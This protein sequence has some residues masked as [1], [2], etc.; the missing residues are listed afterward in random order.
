MAQRK[1]RIPIPP[2][3]AAETLFRSDRTCCVCHIPDR[4][5]QI[6]H[7]N[8]DPSDNGPHNLA[9]L[10]LECHGQTQITGGF[11]RRLNANL[12][13]LYRDHWFAFVET[14]RTSELLKADQRRYAESSRAGVSV[15]DASHMTQ[16]PI[17]NIGA[18]EASDA[19]VH[20]FNLLAE[21]LR[22]HEPHMLE[23]AALEN[24]LADITNEQVGALRRATLKVRTAKSSSDVERMAEEL[25]DELVPLTAQ[26]SVQAYALRR[27]DDETQRGYRTILAIIRKIPP[28]QVDDILSLLLGSIRRLAKGRIKTMVSSQMAYETTNALKGKTPRLDSV[29]ENMEET[30]MHMLVGRDRYR[31][32][33]RDLDALGF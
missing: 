14:R 24:K 21:K 6:H 17:G 13:I 1:L 29:V 3:V 22:E 7:I 16:N 18:G 20:Q 26:Y 11:G 33:L 15:S 12:V 23:I 2:D 5:V 8:D 32:L 10:C 9:V 31:D 27:L 25:V 30:R 4:Q 28:D 19:L